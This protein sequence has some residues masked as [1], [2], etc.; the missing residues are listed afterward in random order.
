MPPQAR[1]CVCL[2]VCVCVIYGSAGC[3][4][5]TVLVRTRAV[6]G[7]WS[8]ETDLLWQSVQQDAENLHSCCL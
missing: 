3:F 6:L 8:F 7:L 1:T 2:C 4:V 5:W